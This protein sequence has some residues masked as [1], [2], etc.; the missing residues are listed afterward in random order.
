MPVFDEFEEEPEI[1]FETDKIKL[2]IRVIRRDINL[3]RRIKKMSEMID[4]RIYEHRYDEAKELTDYIYTYASELIED[5]E[6]ALDDLYELS[7]E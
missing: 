3:A 7:K 2:L 1:V 6:N 4:L 5:L